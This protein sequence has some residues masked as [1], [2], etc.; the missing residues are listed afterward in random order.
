MHTFR[1]TYAIHSLENGVDLRYLQNIVGC[2]S[3]KTTENYT[4]I[5]T[6]GIDEIKSLLNNLDI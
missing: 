6:K 1:H 5:T 4:H 3:S 2:K